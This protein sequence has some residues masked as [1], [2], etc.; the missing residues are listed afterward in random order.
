MSTNSNEIQTTSLHSSC[1]RF[2]NS[3]RSKSSNYP[4]LLPTHK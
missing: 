4:K 2:Y 3:G 1:Y